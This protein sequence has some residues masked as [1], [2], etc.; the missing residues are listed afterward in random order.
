MAELE[1]LDVAVYAAVAEV[2]TPTLDERFRQLALL[3]DHSKL[4]LGI[5]G[6][7][8]LLE[9]GAAARPRST[10]WWRSASPRSSS[11]SPSSG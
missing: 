9:A 1:D 6:A 7:T 8:A 10:G 11:T 5:A 4:W 3:A 2:P